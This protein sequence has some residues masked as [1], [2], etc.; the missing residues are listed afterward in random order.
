MLSVPGLVEAFTLGVSHIGDEESH[1]AD[2]WEPKHA[3]EISDVLFGRPQ[4]SLNHSDLE[5]VTHL[6]THARNKR[7]LFVTTDLQ[8]LD[9]ASRLAALGIRVATPQDALQRG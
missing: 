8:M 3:E 6:H 7:D 5:D 2:D 4:A 1:L 9:R